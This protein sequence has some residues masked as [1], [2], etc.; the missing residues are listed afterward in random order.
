ME[1]V[2][3]QF[4]Y[5]SQI[6]W[7]WYGISVLLAFGAGALWYTVLFG[8]QWIKVV[9]YECACGANLS[10]GEECKCKSRFPWEMIFQFVS[11]VIIGIMYFLL[12]SVSVAL[13]IIV[14][15]AFAGW[16][17]SMLKFQIADWNRYITH[18]LIDVGY[19]TLVSAIFIVFSLL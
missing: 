7:M 19:F 11:T 12:T 10:K 5:F 14:C 16:T 8:K 17:K 13:A 3:G 9:N 6:S 18:A 2:F 4:G 15:L 1:A